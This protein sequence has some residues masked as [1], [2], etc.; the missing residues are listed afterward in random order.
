MSNTLTRTNM[1]PAPALELP[2][3]S[4]CLEKDLVEVGEVRRFSPRNLETPEPELG[5]L[6]CTPSEAVS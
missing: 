3:L 5:D 6:E 1:L 2:Q 4:P